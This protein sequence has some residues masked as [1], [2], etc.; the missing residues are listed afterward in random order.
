[1]LYWLKIIGPLAPTYWIVLPAANACDALRVCSDDGCVRSFV[2]HL[3]M[4]WT[5]TDGFVDFDICIASAKA[6]TP[7]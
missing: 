7:S 3:V 6:M 5:Y 1:M 2:S 4:Y